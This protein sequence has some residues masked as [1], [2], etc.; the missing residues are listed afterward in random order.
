MDYICSVEFEEDLDWGVQVDQGN[1]V[2][3]AN[4]SSEVIRKWK[5]LT[6]H[7]MIILHTSLT[8][9]DHHQAI[10]PT[11][12]HYVHNEPSKRPTD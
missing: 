10:L 1:Q 4:H 8:T 7:E 6:V 11:K 3:C 12:Q 2:F 5:A 9:E